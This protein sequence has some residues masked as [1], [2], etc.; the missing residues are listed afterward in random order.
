MTCRLVKKGL[1]TP[2]VQRTLAVGLDGFEV[3]L[4]DRL[5]A[6]GEL[7]ALSALRDRSATYL[8]DH[9]SAARTGLAWEH[10]ASGL[11]PEAA[12]RSGVVTLDPDTYS[13][14]QEGARFE[15]FFEQLEAR[16]VV[17]DAPYTDLTRA[18][19]VHGVVAWGS[20]DP[21]VPTTANPASLLSEA[22]FPAYPARSAIYSNPWPSADGTRTMAGE[23]AR[24]ITT[25]TDAATWLLGRRLPDWDLAIVVAGEPH[26]GAEALWHGIDIEHPLHGHP[27]AAPAAEGLGAIY[28]ACDHLVARLVE[29]TAADQ[30]LVFSMGGMGTNQSDVTSMVLLPELLFRWATGGSLLEVRA[31]W[32][33]DPTRVPLFPVG[34]TWTT[35]SRTW[36]PAPEV[37]R[38]P[39]RKLAARLPG[40]IKRRIR[41][42]VPG[43]APVPAT[44]GS[45]SLHWQPATRYQTWWH[46]MAAFALPSFYDGRI[47]VNLRGR[48]RRGVVDPGDYE[49]VCKEIIEMLHAC[50]DVRTGESVVAS[51]EQVEP[52][53]AMELDGGGA[54]LLVVWRTG[55]YA[56]EHPDLGVIGPVPLRRTGGH[57]GPYGF[58]Y[59]TAPGLTPGARGVRSAFDVA[60]TVVELTGNSPISGMSG[61][62]MLAA[63]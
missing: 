31:E 42:L 19:H 63:D 38:G 49:R 53:E 21:G 24:G 33:A 52:A 8:L 50:R 27:S 39:V 17:F 62:S 22:G 11:T 25:R 15:P 13:V 30:V 1:A 56:F 45:L 32:A 55:A 14:W 43:T 46:E 35:A 10:F 26:S 58:A 51:I 41:T 5:I 2:M 7:P 60:P 37:T 29:E 6:A 36:Y 54:D 34:E 59:L 9:G 4:V 16:T 28:R 47:R 48:E 23:L 44:R 20:H 61:R 57:T 18:P 12:G 40:S 3:S